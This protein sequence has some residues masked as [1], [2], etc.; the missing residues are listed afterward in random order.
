MDVLK[1]LIEKMGIDKTI[2]EASEFVE[3]RAFNDFRYC[4]DS[5]KLEML[6]WNKTISFEE[7]IKRTILWYKQNS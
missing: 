3:D 2:E 7:G 5:S 1:T 4:I 6:G